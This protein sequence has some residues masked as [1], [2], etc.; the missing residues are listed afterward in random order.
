MHSI[1]TRALSL[2]LLVV[3]P[4]PAVAQGLPT[5]QPPYLLLIREDVKTGRG[6]EHARIE[7]G[8]VAA[9]ERA[10]SPDYYLAMESATSTEAWF[11]IPFASYAAL[12]ESLARER[13][14]VLGPELTRLRRADAE[15]INGWRAVQLRARPELSTGAYPDLAKQRHWSVGVFRMR[16]GGEAVFADVAKAYGAASR[17]AGGTTAYRVYEVR[18]GMPMPTYFVF[19][20]VTAFGEFDKAIADD[21]AAMK[22]MLSGADAKVL[23][24]WTEK[25]INSEEF[26]LSLSPEMSYVPPDVRVS[27]PAF[28]GPK[29]AGP[30]KPA[31]APKPTSTQP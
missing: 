5:S 6:A 4:I 1:V 17:S 19:S 20:S 28:W 21:E 18:A 25:L 11:A 9:F 13:G 29:K 30:P 26:I 8:W 15:V 10:K 7:A 24:A 3:A 23:T 14:P 31:P 22:Q 27:D 12:G 2:A 16:P